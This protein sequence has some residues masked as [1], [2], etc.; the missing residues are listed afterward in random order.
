MV[1]FFLI[2]V[3]SRSHCPKR[4]LLHA[5]KWTRVYRDEINSYAALRCERFGGDRTL[6]SA[7]GQ[8]QSNSA[9]V[10]GRPGGT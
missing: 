2:C 9:A 7:R 8:L 1:L 10:L 4:E 6:P 5:L 3:L